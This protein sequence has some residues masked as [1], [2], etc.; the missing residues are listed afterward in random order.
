MRHTHTSSLNSNIKH[1]WLLLTILV[2]TLCCVALP[3]KAFAIIQ[4]PT[5][6]NAVLMPDGTIVNSEFTLDGS[7]P[8]L[9]TDIIKN[10]PI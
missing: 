6:I 7:I 9:L 3:T 1:L 8:S 2:A 5:D 10:N 4:V